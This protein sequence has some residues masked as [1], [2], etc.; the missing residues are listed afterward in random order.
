M[1]K[2]P[3]R[4]TLRRLLA[5]ALAGL[6]TAAVALGVAE[7]AAA[8]ISANSAPV[9]AVGETA[10]N[11]TPIPVKEFAITHFGS[12]DKE[13]LLAGIVVMLI[14]FAALIGIAAVRR[15]GYGLAGLAVFAAVGAAAAVHLPGGTAIDVIPTLAG[16]LVGA[17][18]MVVLI[19]ALWA[20]F[21]STG[22]AS[23]TLVPTTLA[24]T[25][26]APTELAPE[27]LA[28]E[29]LAPEELAPEEGRL[30]GP[31]AGPAGGDI[32]AE[33]IPAEDVLAEDVLAAGP[34][35]SDL[36]VPAGPYLAGTTGPTWL[37]G[38]GGPEAR[39]TRSASSP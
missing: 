13:A 1:I 19:R 21:P 30:A 2:P 31:D 37:A 4:A 28:P 26:L 18:A 25:T 8:L 24:P 6:L 34:Y 36:G 32:P 35:L 39:D 10:I 29:E 27:E 12:H 38:P 3:G 9:I 20:A 17:G 22:L 11:L 14:V 5:G 15:I 33:D 23:A 16:V 7:L